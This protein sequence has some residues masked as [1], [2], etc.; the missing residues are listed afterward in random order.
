MVIG[1][2]FAIDGTTYTPED[3]LSYDAVGLAGVNAEAG[4]SISTAHK[5]LPMPSYVEITALEGGRTILARVERR[6]PMANDR[7]IELSP[8]AASQLGIGDVQKAAPVRVRRV[9]PPEFERA[10]LRSGQRAPERMDTPKSLL[11]VLMRKLEP[12]P[13][14]ASG[15]QPAALTTT[16]SAPEPMPQANPELRHEPAPV[17]PPERLAPAT[18][19]PIAKPF[20]V[21]VAAFSTRARADAAAHAIGGA[22][23]PAGKLFRM[24]LGPLATR[25]EAEAAL[26]KARRAGYSDARIQRMP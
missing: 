21:Q 4:A 13:P 15:P 19:Q 7:L 22:I 3:R 26:A 8:G 10:L 11:A 17:R 14:A 6:G 1:A 5:T 16:R 9:N 12:A 24:R 25:A 20:F 2:P 23:E 18:P